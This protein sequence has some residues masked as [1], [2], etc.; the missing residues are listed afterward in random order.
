MGVYDFGFQLFMN[1]SR[2]FTAMM[3]GLLLAGM[4]GQAQV[5]RSPFMQKA[6]DQ[7]EAQAEAPVEDAELQ[8]CGTF[9]DGDQKR[10]LIYNKTRNRSEWIKIGEEGPE[11]IFVDAYDRE[12]S[13][14][15]VR[16]GGQT[17]SLALQAATISAAAAR[18]QTPVTLAGNSSDLIKTVRVNPSPTDERRRLEAVAAEVRRRRALRQSAAGGQAVESGVT[19]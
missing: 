18:P 2:T 10:F 13:T 15:V 4:G 1:R 7:V 19:P 5:L 16:Q 3:A 8:F 14:V 9:G 17:L 11:G 6:P 12:E